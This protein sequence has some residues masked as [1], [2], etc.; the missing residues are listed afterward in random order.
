MNIERHRSQLNFWLVWVM[1]N[2]AGLA[3][4]WAFGEALG[5]I[6]VRA[7]GR[8]IGYLTAWIVFET[9]VWLMRWSVLHRLREFGVWRPLDTFI[10][11]VAEAMGWLIGE[12]LSQVPGPM[13]VTAGAI[14]AGLLGASVWI[15]I[16]LMRQPRTSNPW[17]PVTVA[18]WTF[19]G[20]VGG[21]VTLKPLSRRRPN[22]AGD[23]ALSRHCAVI[24]PW[25]MT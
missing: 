12:G 21:R 25:Y 9:I 17:W 6:A 24:L 20:F 14:W 5:Q 23:G 18:I 4:G 16:W 8:T 15:V 2:V 13:W 1:A 19:I 11:V 10:W 3:C 22:R 7:S